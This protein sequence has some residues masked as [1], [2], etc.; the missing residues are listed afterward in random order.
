MESKLLR[1]FTKDD[2]NKLLY[3]L[4]ENMEGH[5]V[6]KLVLLVDRSEKFLQQDGSKTRQDVAQASK[7]E[8]LACLPLST[9]LFQPRRDHGTQSNAV[10]AAEGSERQDFVEARLGKRAGGERSRGE[11]TLRWRRGEN[12]ETI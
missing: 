8:K 10:D 1:T 2:A 5:L 3:G 7:V 6:D 9:M 4:E 12:I 11:Y